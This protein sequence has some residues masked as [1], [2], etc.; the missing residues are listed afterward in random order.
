MNFKTI[1]L[2][3]ARTKDFPEG[4]RNRGYEFCAPLDEEGHLDVEEWKRHRKKCTVR[5]FW[6]GEDEENGFLVHTRRREWAFSYRAG[7]ED[8]EPIFP[9]HNGETLPFKV[10]LVH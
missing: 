1:R 9:E 3:L 2:E 8:D 10:I 4:S 7:E 5:R 6:E